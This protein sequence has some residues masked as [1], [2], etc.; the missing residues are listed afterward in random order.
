MISPFLERDCFE[1]ASLT[2][3]FPLLRIVLS[4]KDGSKIALYC[5]QPRNEQ[6]V[7]LARLACLGSVL[8]PSP[9]LSNGLN[10]TYGWWMFIMYYNVL[11]YCNLCTYILATVR[12]VLCL[13]DRH[14]LGH[15]LHS[16]FLSTLYM[17]PEHFWR[18]SGLVAS[19]HGLCWCQILAK[20]HGFGAWNRI[21]WMGC[22]E[23]AIENWK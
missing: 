13:Q 4:V 7:F 9:L 14:N 10:L 3:W 12:S 20:F 19:L 16:A 6:A 11:Q 2:R 5:L 22:M 23:K 8:Q 18:F 21:H 15:S 1:K 17:S